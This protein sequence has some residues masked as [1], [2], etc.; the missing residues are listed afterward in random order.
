MM[1]ES[2]SSGHISPPFWCKPTGALLASLQTQAGGLSQAEA[3]R[4]LIEFGPNRAVTAQSRS[5]LRK[6]G[7]RVLNPLV[8]ILLVAAAISGFSGDVGSFVIIVTVV[9]MSLILDIAQE[10]RAEIAA[11]ALRQSVAIHADVVRNG[12]IVAV[13]VAAVVPGDIV[14]LRTGDL[15]PAD[16]VALE[17]RELQVNEALMTGEPFPAAKRTEP[18][19]STEPAE[20]GNALFSG[21]S[22]VGGDGVMLV[23][24]TGSRTRFGAIAA[25][26]AANAPPTAIEQGVQRLGML[27]L[28]LTLFLTLFVLVAHIAAGRPAMESFLFAVALA[29][30][31]TPE[32]LPMVMTVTLARGAERMAARQVI[33]KRLSAIHDLGAMDVLC[34]DKTGTLTEARITLEGY[35]DAEGKSSA[36]VLELAR[37]NAAFQAGVRSPLDDALLAGAGEPPKDYACLS[38]VPFDFRRRCLSVL[39]ARGPDKLLIV[40]GAPEAILSR[41]VAVEIDGVTRPLDGDQLGKIEA[42]LNRYAEEGFRLIGVAAKAA[43]GQK[44]EAG[45]ADESELTLAGFCVFADPPKRDASDTIASLAAS[46]IRLK[47]IS[48]DHVAVVSHVAAAVGLPSR[49]ILTGAEIEQLADSALLAKVDDVDLFARIDPDQKRRIIHALRLRGHVVGFLGD[50]VNDAPAIHAAHV[51]ISVSGAT[52]VAR[53]AADMIL[54]AQDLSVLEAGV[55]EGRRTIANILKYVRMG[56][57]SNFGNM[58]SMALASVV[59]PFLPLLPLQ[60]LLNNLLYD[61]SEIGIPFDEVDAEDVAQPHGWDMASILRF[62]LVMGAV[63][64][65]FD[66][67]T[68]LVLL[69]FFHTDAALFQTGW[70]LESIATQILVIFLIRSRRLP[71]RANL[72]HPVLMATS[73]GALAIAIVLATGPLRELFGFA[74]LPTALTAGIALITLAY[75]AVAEAAKRI[76]LAPRRNLDAT[77]VSRGRTDAGRV[78]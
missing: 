70:F 40:N 15:V 29:V 57:S 61:L 48:G 67:A 22:V 6:L 14:H 46:G 38:E 39:V 7:R 32:L 59:L 30:G 66:A 44:N 17:A 47:I 12:A 41:A 20:A 1:S 24:E 54:L 65:L 76:A 34:V 45:L 63:S 52:E 28:Q 10:H 36:R 49:G 68:F 73:L 72:P 13:S 62:T 58:L 56:T 77:G 3:E 27:I 37:L 53:A 60:I 33:V 16:G 11:E 35:I 26:L 23:V 9:A 21:T 8:A 4:R 75:L 19:A 43:P 78:R 51:G 71:W 74:A 55:R 42:M 25:A 18:S 5:I 31:L 64:S 2:S 69:K 50:G